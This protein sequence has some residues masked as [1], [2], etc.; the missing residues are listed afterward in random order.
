LAER[1][2]RADLDTPA[3]DPARSFKHG[4]QTT[5]VRQTNGR[6]VI[7]AAGLNG[8]REAFAV[9]RVIGHEP[10]RQ[11]LTALPGGRFQAHEASYD[12][13]HNEWFNVYGAEDRM[14]G[15]WGHWTGRGMNWNS[16]CAACHNTRLRKNYDLAAD[17]YHTTMAE[18][19]VGCE[20]CHGP[21]RAHV[22]WRSG[23][24]AGNGP[25]P[26]VKKFSA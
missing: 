9:D 11:F 21:M 15:E 23:H 4:T 10:L 22:E 26:T 16:T 25:D 6:P 19:S 24:P 1:T 18:P 20:S 8:R 5:E 13:L 7:V 17:A 14:P 3:F 12:P 2:L